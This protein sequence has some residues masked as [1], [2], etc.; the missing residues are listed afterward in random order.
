MATSRGTT[1]A[2]SQAAALLQLRDKDLALIPC[3]PIAGMLDHDLDAP[4][5]WTTARKHRFYSDAFVSKDDRALLQFT[6]APRFGGDRLRGWESDAADMLAWIDALKAPKYFGTIDMTLASQGR[7]TFGARC[8]QCHGRQEEGAQYPGISA[9]VGTDPLRLTGLSQQFKE[10]YASSWLGR[11]GSGGVVT[12]P[13]QY[14]APPLNGIWAS[15]PY[16]HNGS[17]PTLAHV[18]NSPSR[19]TVWRVPDYDAY[20]TNRL[21][22]RVDEYSEIPV[23]ETTPSQRRRYISTKDPG[24]SNAGH[25]FGDSLTDAQ[26]RALLEFL[27]TL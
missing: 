14:V 1:T 9:D 13:V 7:T 2:F 3:A 11:Y 21:G 24:L 23:S 5:W 22:L 15:A 26:R 12:S 18:L 20:D 4:A 16:F 27:K 17:V 25:T 6:M 19:P 10:R 8:A